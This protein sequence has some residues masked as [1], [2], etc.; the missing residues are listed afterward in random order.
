MRFK[1]FASLAIAATATAM[2]TACS[3]TTTAPPPSKAQQCASGLSADCLLGTWSVDDPIIPTP[4]G[5]DT[6]YLVDQSHNLSAS[7]A[8]LKFYVDDKKANKFEYTESSLA[9][10]CKSPTGKM[11]G[12]WSITGNSLYLYA[13]IGSEC[14]AQNSTTIVPEITIDVDKVYMKFGSVFFMGPELDGDDA[15]KKTIAAEK[16]TFVSAE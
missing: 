14:M 11:Y 15:V 3:E 9:K 1:I 8:T 4:V 16:Y 6:V 12:N 5:T 2:F 7:P 10:G 13:N